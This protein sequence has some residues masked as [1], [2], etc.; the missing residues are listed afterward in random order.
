M[1]VEF[2][3]AQNKD[4][5]AWD[6]IISKSPYGTLFHQWEWLKIT[7]KNTQTKLYPVMGMKN[8]DCIGVFPLFFQKKGPARMVFSPPPHAALF[9]LGPVMVSDSL[10]QEKWENLYVAFL[11]SVEN[12]IINDL[13]G[14]FISFSL[15]PNLQDPRPFIWKGYAIELN[16]DYTVDLSLGIEY[17]YSILDRKQR[18]DLKRAEGKGMTVEMGEKK[19]LETILDLMD[20]RYT[21]QDKI[22]TA[23]RNYFLDIYDMFR[24]NLKIFVVKFEGEIITGTIDL[25][26]KDSLYC[27]IGNPKPINPISPS[28]NDLLISVCV[29]YASENGLKYHTTFGAAGNERLH[30]YYATKFNPGLGIRYTVTKKSFLTALLKKGYTDILK[31][32]RGRI[33]HLTSISKIVKI[34][35]P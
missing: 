27:W 26:Y 17:L 29:R 3:I 24:D 22:V 11:Q 30:T 20:I 16:F 10:R 33:K 31:P 12:F 23:S 7:E 14:N 6:A 4:A 32:L 2:L 5:K 25:A 13:K 34:K 28:P 15:S 1:T 21:Q 18:A 8:G 35:I 9:Y 19:D